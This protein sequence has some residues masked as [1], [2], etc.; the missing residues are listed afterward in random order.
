MSI[1]DNQIDLRRP[2]L[3]YILEQATPAIFTDLS[4]QARKASTSLLPSRSTPSAVSRTVESVRSPW[5]ACKVHPVE[6]QDT[7]VPLERTLSPG[8]KL[9]RQRVIETTHC[10]GALSHSR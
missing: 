3:T 9:L 10:A 7:P 4:A 2:T 1:G 6:I 5:R 8:F